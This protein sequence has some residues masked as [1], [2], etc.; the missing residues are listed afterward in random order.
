MTEDATELLNRASAVDP[1]LALLIDRDRRLGLT[2]EEILLLLRR[3]MASE[4]KRRE[5]LVKERTAD[6]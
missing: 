3:A 2:D 4:T 5:A 1:A 6:V